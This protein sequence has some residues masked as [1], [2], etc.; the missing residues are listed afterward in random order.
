MPAPT[1]T[2]I[3]QFIA[4]T[5]AN[6]SAVYAYASDASELPRDA[7]QVASYAQLLAQIAAGFQVSPEL[8]AAHVSATGVRPSSLVTFN[9]WL[10]SEGLTVDSVPP[11]G[12]KY[13][14]DRGTLTTTPPADDGPFGDVFGRLRDFWNQSPENKAIV[15]GGA[16]AAYMLLGRRR[17]I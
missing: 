15:I 6:P 9:R 1:R 8:V 10:A 12:Y 3:Q 16:V 13:R 2:Q 14:H 7:A 11:A 5:G 4:D 17:L